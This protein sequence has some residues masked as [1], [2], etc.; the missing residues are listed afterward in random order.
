MTQ[1]YLTGSQTNGQIYNYRKDI[2]PVVK[3]IKK[4]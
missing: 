2:V 1:M 4:R 3:Y